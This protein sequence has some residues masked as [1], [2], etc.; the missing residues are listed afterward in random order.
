M[1]HVVLLGDSVFDNAPYV[2][3]NP[4]VPQQVRDLLSEGS[5]A[6]LLARDGT[7]IAGVARQLDSLPG[8]ATHLV[9]SAGGNDAL[10]LS[11]IFDERAASVSNAV[12]MLAAVADLFGRNYSAMLDDA[13]KYRLPVAVCTIYEPRFPEP[14]RRRV[15]AAGLT[16]LNDRVTREAFSRGLTLIDLRVICDHDEDFT[17]SIEP[18]ARGGAKIAAAVVRFANG[19]SSSAVIAKG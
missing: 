19:A 3:G 8:T 1:K 6:T 17:N 12:E 10:Q 7:L 16:L 9:I 2:G 4:D 5:Q 15:A 14:R 18:S 13:V 11:G